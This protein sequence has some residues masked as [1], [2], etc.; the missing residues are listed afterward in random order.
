MIARATGDIDVGANINT[1]GNDLRLFADDDKDG[2][3]ALSFTG[4]SA[5][6]NGRLIILD[7]PNAPTASAT[8]ITVVAT[9]EMRIRTS[10]NTT[11]NLTLTAGGAL[12]FLTRAITLNGADI[13]LTAATAPRASNRALTITATGALVID[14]R[15]NTGGGDLDLTGATLQFGSA[16]GSNL[17]LIGRNITLT[18]TV[19]TAAETGPAAFWSSARRMI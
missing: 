15:L 4:T 13:T 8:A 11:G 7:A 5:A 2:S 18:S 16:T 6:L 3:G 9:G 12:N 19:A 10:I 17:I 1:G 14:A